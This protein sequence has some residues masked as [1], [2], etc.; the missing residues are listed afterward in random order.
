MPSL[1][2]KTCL[3]CFRFNIA[4]TTMTYVLN[5]IKREKKMEAFMMVILLSVQILCP[6]IPVNINNPLIQDFHT[7]D[8]AGFTSMAEAESAFFTKLA[9][10]FS[11]CAPTVFLSNQL[12]EIRFSLFLCSP[13]AHI[14]SPQPSLHV[15]LR[16]TRCFLPALLISLIVIPLS[17]HPCYYPSQARGFWS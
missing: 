17:L 15:P 8:N 13:P 14:P 3:F 6:N 4:L 16:E 1:C 7:A 9:L 10:L 11:T 12:R 5:S 2:M